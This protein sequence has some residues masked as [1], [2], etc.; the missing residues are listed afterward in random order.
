MYGHEV[1]VGV[2]TSNELA[3]STH[4]SHGILGGVQECDK[5]RGDSREEGMENGEYRIECGLDGREYDLEDRG[6]QIFDGSD[7]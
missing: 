7:D 4:S 2:L 3:N 5:N 1:I 6:D